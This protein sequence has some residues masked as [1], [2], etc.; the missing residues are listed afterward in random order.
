MS[1]GQN[2]LTVVAESHGE[3]VVEAVV[4]RI[5]QSG[6]LIFLMIACSFAGL[7]T[8][9]LMMATIQK[10][11]NQDTMVEYGKLMKPD[12]R[13]PRFQFLGPNTTK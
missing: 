11:T 12:F 8:S 10:H 3:T 5:R 7:L 4:S 1:V 13:R 9:R 6:I 2:D